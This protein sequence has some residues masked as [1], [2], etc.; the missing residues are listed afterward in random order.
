MPA[1][2]WSWTPDY[3]LEK[4]TTAAVSEVKFGDGYTQRIRRGINTVS[5]TWT[6][7]F[8]NRPSA[9]VD[10]MEAFLKQHAGAL[11]FLWP[12]HNDPEDPMKY[13]K[14]TCEKWRRQ[15]TAP[16]HDTLTMTLVQVFDI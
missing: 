3:G 6:V 11:Y 5:Q 7:T 1:L 2:V 4:E 16:Y 13:I 9:V 10:A 12:D 8:G 15:F 14:V